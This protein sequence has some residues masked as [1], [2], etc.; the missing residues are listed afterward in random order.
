MISFFAVNED[1]LTRSNDRFHTE[2][3]VTKKQQPKL[4]HH[5]GMESRVANS[6]NETIDATGKQDAVDDE[7]ES[8]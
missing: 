1:S 5:K 8:Y 6:S 3:T 4:S 2:K 7:F